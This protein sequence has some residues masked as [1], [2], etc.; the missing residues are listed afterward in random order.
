MQTDGRPP[1]WQ[2]WSYDRAELIADGVVHVIGVTLG[3]VAAVA[4]IIAAADRVKATEFASVLVYAIGLMS[5]LGISATY[6][7]WPV[8]KVKWWLRRFDHSAIYILIAGTY[9]PFLVQLPDPAIANPLLWCLW[10]T[11]ALG[12]T[13]KFTFPGRFDGFAI[14]LY[15][16]LGWSGIVAYESVLKT[17]DTTTLMLLAAGGLLYSAGIVFHLWHSLRFQNAIWHAFV[18]AAAGCHFA[19]VLDGVV[20]TRL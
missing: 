13:L 6:N 1:S 19:A 7:M 14:A 2:S 12:I 18:L 11:A 9:T 3:L 10:L 17:F 8:T 20:L 16:A 15:L 5:V 4:L